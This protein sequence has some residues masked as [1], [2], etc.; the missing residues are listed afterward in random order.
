MSTSSV[1]LAA[2]GWCKRVHVVAQ[3]VPC[4]SLLPKLEAASNSEDTQTLAFPALTPS[5]SV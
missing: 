4:T 3:S 5:H 2:L 1:Q